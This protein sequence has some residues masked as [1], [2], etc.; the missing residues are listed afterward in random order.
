MS[1]GKIKARHPLSGI[2]VAPGLTTAVIRLD[3]Q[4]RAV[5]EG[6]RV[7]PGHHEAV[8]SNVFK[9]EESKMEMWYFR[10]FEAVSRFFRILKV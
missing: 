2:R 1:N 9:A 6:K 4:G 3:G 8:R 5:G 10:L 7:Y